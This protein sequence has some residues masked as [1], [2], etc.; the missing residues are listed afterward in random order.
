M[1]AGK[2]TVK[3]PNDCNGNTMPSFVWGIWVANCVPCTSLCMPLVYCVAILFFMLC[4][5]FSLLL[6]LLFSLL[7]ETGDTFSGCVSVLAGR[8]LSTCFCA[9]LEHAVEAA[10]G[11]PA[12]LQR[13]F[14]SNKKVCP[15]NCFAS[16]LHAGPFAMYGIV[17]LGSVSDSKLGPRRHIRIFTWW[18]KYTSNPSPAPVQ[19]HDVKFVN[20]YLNVGVSAV[21]SSS[22]F[23]LHIPL[24]RPYQEINDRL[25]SR[26]TWQYM[27]HQVYSTFDKIKS[28]QICSKCSI[29]I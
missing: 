24:P 1:I 25:Q 15:A 21:I 17:F 18:L 19:L 22:A 9:D 16:T 4:F 6:L 27:S 3:P 12:N 8:D 29:L 14:F 26:Y 2:N 7:V 10:T 28:I 20:L 11:L 23:I 13:F 5:V